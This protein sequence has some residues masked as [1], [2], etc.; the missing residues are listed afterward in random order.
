LSEVAVSFNVISDARSPLGTLIAALHE[1]FEVDAFDAHMLAYGVKLA[2]V[3]ACGKG[4]DSKE[5][6]G[7]EAVVVVPYLLKVKDESRKEEAHQ[8]K[9]RGEFDARRVFDACEDDVLLQKLPRDHFLE[10]ELVPD[11]QALPASPPENP[12]VRMPAEVA[13]VVHV[14]EESEDVGRG[15]VELNRVSKNHRPP[16]CALRV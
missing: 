2:F 13:R 12:V 4:T 6:L 8:P 11:L 10:V 9:R 5:D 15:G 7:Y 14:F 16:Q 3:E 1:A